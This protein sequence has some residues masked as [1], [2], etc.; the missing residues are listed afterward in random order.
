[1]PAVKG[2]GKWQVAILATLDGQPRAARDLITEL[3]G[4]EPTQAQYTAAHR[5]A[6]SLI[7]SG[8]LAAWLEP[9]GHLRLLVLVK[10][11]HVSDGDS[12]TFTEQVPVVAV[13]GRERP[14]FT[15]A[16]AAEGQ[17]A[18]LAWPADRLAAFTDEAWRAF[19]TDCSYAAEIAEAAA[20]LAAEVQ[21]APRRR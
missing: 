13:R 12:A 1:M 11:H 2:G 3:V 4:G 16:E 19:R 20:D 15:E 7:A 6:R 10:P 17:R 18:S 21:I 5:A 9:A 8:E 14:R